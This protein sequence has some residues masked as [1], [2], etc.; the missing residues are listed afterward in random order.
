MRKKGA[1]AW[2][3]LPVIRTQDAHL[4]DTNVCTVL[5]VPCMYN[6][7]AL[8][9]VMVVVVVVVVAEPWKEPVAQN[10]R[11]SFTCQC[12]IKPNQQTQ[13]KTLYHVQFW[14]LR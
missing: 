7:M 12:T 10:V 1:V 11:I 9:A 2:A 3:C 13:K 14:T 8:V 4:P 5:G 6:A